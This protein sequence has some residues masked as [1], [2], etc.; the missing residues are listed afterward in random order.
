[1]KKKH[2]E[3]IIFFFQLL[4]LIF[5][6]CMALGIN[7]FVIHIVRL[8]IKQGDVASIGIVISIIAMTVF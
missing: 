2:E 5:V 6:W 3:K 7:G 1:M 8:A 4:P